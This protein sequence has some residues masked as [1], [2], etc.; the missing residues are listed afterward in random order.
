MTFSKQN[1]P[2]LLLVWEFI[3][4]YVSFATSVWM[5]D[6]GRGRV[7]PFACFVYT[8][9]K[10]I[11]MKIG[12]DGLHQGLLTHLFLVHYNPYFTRCCNLILKIPLRTGSYKKLVCNIKYMSHVRIRVN[13]CGIYGGQSGTQTGFSPSSS[14][15]PPSMSFHHHSPYS[16][17][18]WGWTICPLVA[19][20]QRHSL[21]PSKSTIYMSH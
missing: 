5:Y 14:V 15:F 2:I 19:A 8:T 1:K 9:T 17:I 6:G 21:T 12:I 3:G 18:I 10:L 7:I 11:F 20:V 13:P 4:F 16:Y